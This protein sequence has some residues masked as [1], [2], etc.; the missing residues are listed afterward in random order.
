MV[1]TM[2]LLQAL[3][4]TARMVTHTTRLA[5]G[6]PPDEEVYLD[7]PDDRLAPALAA[8]GLGDHRPAAEVLAASR[9]AAAWETRDRQVQ[10]LAA[11]ARNRPEWF[12]AWSYAAPHDP[13]V[14]LIRAELAVRR[15]WESPARAELLHDVT[16]LIAAA[17]RAEP[18][19]P[20]PWRIAL[21]HAR[22]T[23]AP[24]T[25]F[26][27]RWEQAVRRSSYHYGC[28][29]AA[30]QYLS[31]AW[32]GSHRES[33]A[34]AER[35]AEDALPGSLVRGLPVRAAFG[36]LHRGPDAPGR[37]GPVLRERLDAA[38][39]T[40]IA[41]SAE[42]PAGDPWPAEVRNVLLYVL[43]RLER[44]AD[45][46]EQARLIGTRATSFPWDRISDDP[47]GQFLQARD[48][49]RIEVAASLPLLGTR[50][51]EKAGDH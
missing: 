50:R 41:L 49:V 39:D 12:D 10:R 38:A 29:V 17:A 36:A 51:R 47:L 25:E 15:G 18:A 20:V 3:I 22:G 26:E 31:A 35:A 5:T 44:W 19:D 14:A 37:G 34:F 23:G 30:L 40:A 7:L 45:A 6:L 8:A 9:E 48:G 11:F 32:F 46:L 16:P 33:F 13:D 21:D 27:A 28:H 43:I 24:H 1:G 4:R 2:A 42:Y